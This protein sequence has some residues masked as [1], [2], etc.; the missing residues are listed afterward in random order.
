MGLAERRERSP[1]NHE[2]DGQLASSP[3]WNKRVF[4]GSGR[5]G[6]RI[7]PCVA[8]WWVAL[9]WAIGDAG[10]ERG[11]FHLWTMARLRVPRNS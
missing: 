3:A 7:V 4:A 2:H 9:V 6:R 11:G 8:I 10:E 5:G 1:G